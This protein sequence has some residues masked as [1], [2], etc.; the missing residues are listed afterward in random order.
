[1]AGG[2]VAL[3]LFPAPHCLFSTISVSASTCACF[4]FP[5]SSLYPMLPFYPTQ[6]Q[7]PHT[8][9]T[10]CDPMWCRDVTKD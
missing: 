1:M 10:E 8:H 9:P 3:L 4:L 7:L 2:A 6:Y 5:C